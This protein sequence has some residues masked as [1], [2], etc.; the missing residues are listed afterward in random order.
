MKHLLTL[1]SL[2]ASFFI[3]AQLPIGVRTITYNDP[4]RTGGVG[5]GGGPGRQIECAVYYPATSAGN[6]TPVANGEFPVVVFGHGF[7]MQWS[8]YQNVWEFLTP[9][10]FILIFPK[11]ESSIFPAPSHNDFGLDLALAANRMLA[12]NENVASP[13][14]Q[15]VNG[16]SAIM[17][18]SMGGGATVLAAQN[19]NS[20]KTIIGLASAETNPSA[21]AAAE[22]VSVPAL[23]LSGSA[24]G[25]TPPSEHHLPIFNALESTCK[26]FV[27][28]TGGAHCYFANTD[29]ACDFGEGT[30]S[31]GISISRAEQQGF[32]NSLILPWLTFY[33]KEDCAG[34][35]EF[36]E[37]ANTSGLVPNH[38]CDYTPIS[39]DVTISNPDAGQSNG[40]AT[41]T[42]SGGSAPVAFA[43]FDGTTNPELS[44]LSEGSYDFTISDA[45]CTLQGTA[46]VVS[47]T[48]GTDENFLAQVLIFP[49]PTSGN[50]TIQFPV[51]ANFEIT[52]T[53][54]SGRVLIHKNITDSSVYSL[55]LSNTS[56]GMYFVL[57]TDDQEN[58]MRIPILRE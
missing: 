41:V 54:A 43:W 19:N 53:D 35:T 50:S 31:T 7:A 27:S 40:S 51:I 49:N 48:S 44:G 45:L 12:D 26:S 25:V 30:A 2:V 29:F 42:F 55:D 24:D 9:Q 15:K 58:V 18:H 36:M 39:Y 21:V 57:I 5:S 11:T 33:L 46:V 23:I 13:F 20:I 28:I 17:G 52:L 22:N 38:E 32:M 1:S 6:N 8:A 10:G 37:T 4:E 47:E 34:F 16:N 56:A 14:Y 3:F